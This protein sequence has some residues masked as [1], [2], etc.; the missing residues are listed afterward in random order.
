MANGTKRKYELETVFLR[1][2]QRLSEPT[3][4]ALLAWIRA[5]AH[6]PAADEAGREFWLVTPVGERKRL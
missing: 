1:E 3:Q 4:A 5:G 2:A 6:Q